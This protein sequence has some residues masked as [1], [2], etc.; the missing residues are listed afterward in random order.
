MYMVGQFGSSI[1]AGML[2]TC[3][4]CISQGI[5][6]LQLEALV[7]L[8][9]WMGFIAIRVYQKLPSL[10]AVTYLCVIYTI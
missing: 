5:V 4:G 8:Y 3:L 1:Y 2:K 7:P 6:P 9:I 10:H